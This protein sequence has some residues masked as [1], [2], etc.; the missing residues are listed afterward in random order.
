MIS[1]PTA[2]CPVARDLYFKGWVKFEKGS[3]QY[4]YAAEKYRWHIAKCTVCRE[5]LDG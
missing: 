1:H 5:A 2:N 3:K 4:E